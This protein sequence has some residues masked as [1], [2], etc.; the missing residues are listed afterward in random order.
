MTFHAGQMV[1]RVGSEECSDAR[2]REAARKHGYS[3]PN[4]G[5]I[6]TVRTINVWPTWTAIT[7]CEHDNSHLISILGSRYEPAF[8]A[9][10]FRPVKDTSIEVFRQL[11]NPAPETERARN[12]APV[13]AG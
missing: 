5:D 3:Y 6:C 7:L 12:S 10:C 8:D 1:V 11:L 13:T 2:T 4:I 9:E